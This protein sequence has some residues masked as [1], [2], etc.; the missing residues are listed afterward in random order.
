MKKFN[1]YSKNLIALLKS[2]NWDKTK[3]LAETLRNAWLNGNRVYLCGNGGSA[4]NAIHL[5]NDF[6]YGIAKESGLG[7]RVIALPSNSA[8]I[9][10][11]GNDIS[12]DDI[13][14]QQIEVQG[15]KEDILIVLSGSGNSPNV[16]KAIQS[17]KKIGMISFAIVGFTGG[18]CKLISDHVIH[19]QIDDMQISEDMQLI[20]GHMIMQ[21][22]S[23]NPL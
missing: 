12:Y 20:I 13:F 21:W 22:L 7:L 1:N 16:V 17:A 9:T 6:N 19:T 5:A 4:G 11:L 3:L 23:E 2:Q 18:K 14:S 15:E 8:V 10:C